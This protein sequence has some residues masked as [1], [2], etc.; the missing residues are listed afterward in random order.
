MC[1]VI[2][3]F[4]IENELLDSQH[5]IS[6][7]MFN[8]ILSLGTIDTVYHNI[9]SVIQ[10]L[11]SLKF[12][13]RKYLTLFLEKCNNSFT[14]TTNAVVPLGVCNELIKLLTIGHIMPNEHLVYLFGSFVMKNIKLNNNESLLGKGVDQA[15]KVYSIE[16]NEHFDQIY[17]KNEKLVFIYGDVNFFDM[18]FEEVD[19]E[20]KEKF[21]TLKFNKSGKK[22]IIGLMSPKELYDKCN[23]MYDGYVNGMVVKKEMKK[24]KKEFIKIMGNMIFFCEYLWDKDYFNFN[25]LVEYVMALKD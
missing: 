16:V 4:A 2:E 21:I 13:I 7:S 19:E 10:V 5:L 17:S 22:E 3:K 14:T 18:F 12:N 25:Y 9:Y 8:T 20:I 6:F 24:S 23:E 15:D 1:N 11:A